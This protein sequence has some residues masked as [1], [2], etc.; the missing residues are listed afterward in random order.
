MKKNKVRIFIVIF[1]LL[2]FCGTFVSCHQAEIISQKPVIS[3]S[4]LP[5]KYFVE[6]ISGDHFLINVLIPS[7]ASPASYEPSPQQIKQLEE[8]A[9]YLKTGDLGFE[10]SWIFSLEKKL[11]NT[12]F[13]NTSEGINLLEGGS[14]SHG[15]HEH[16][17]DP[18][19][20][21]SPRNVKIIVKNICQAISSFDPENAEFYQANL[22]SFENEIDSLDN[23]INDKLTSC[24][25]RHF[26]IYHPA[27]SYFARDYNLVQIPLEMEGKEPG[28]QHMQHIINVASENN[29]RLILV[30]K[31][32]NIDEA[33]T[34]EGEIN[35]KIV[36]IN[37]LDYNWSEQLLFITEQFV[38][39]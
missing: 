28:F 37:P 29:I 27:L 26:I 7:G 20:W 19:V 21:V 33:K 38:N 2:V 13:Y 39:L 30:Q 1:S 5:Q 25:H 35:G 14:H 24:E 4:I 23:I 17:T 31:E 22:T 32:F 12:K 34:L 3:V 10:K 16:A 11:K 6:K 15:E 18:H 36:V 8:S 9:L